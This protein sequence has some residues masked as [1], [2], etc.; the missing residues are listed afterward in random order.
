MCF[1]SLPDSLVSVAERPGLCALEGQFR[2]GFVQH[3][4]YRCTSLR[5]NRVAS[6]QRPGS[7]SAPPSVPRR[8]RKPS[9][10]PLGRV[11]KSAKSA[12]EGPV[13]PKSVHDLPAGPC[14]ARGCGAVARR[15]LPRTQIWG[16]GT[17]VPRHAR[18]SVSVARGTLPHL[19]VADDLPWCPYALFGSAPFSSGSVLSSLERSTWPSTLAVSK[20]PS[21]MP[22]VRKHVSR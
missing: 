6:V 11:R 12:H 22:C 1:C 18:T 20:T 13:R 21:M 7:G 16:C 15:S 10:V 4:G 19:R 8:A 2:Q 3:R 5:S 14:H 9:Q 17:P